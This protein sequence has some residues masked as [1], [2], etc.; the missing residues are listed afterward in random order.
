MST[1]LAVG[2]PSGFPPGTDPTLQLTL[3]P[4]GCNFL[5][6]LDLRLGEDKFVHSPYPLKMAFLPSEH[7]LLYAVKFGDLPWFDGVWQ[8]HVQTRLHPVALPEGTGMLALQIIVVNANTGKVAALRLANLDRACTALLR[9]NSEQQLATVFDPAGAD[10]WV[11][12]QFARYD[13]SS[14]LAKAALASCTLGKDDPAPFPGPALGTT[15]YHSPLPAELERWYTYLED[16]GHSI[17][18][19]LTAH[20]KP[21][22]NDEN[23]VP[24][25]VKAVTDKGWTVSEEG[26]ILV[27]LPYDNEYGLTTDPKYDEYRYS[28]R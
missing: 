20:Y 23:L 4:G 6:L 12:A 15:R 13:T 16:A 1:M 5:A 24:A 14:K 17:N 18:V 8:A 3:T 21:G 9:E 10:A 7:A 25:P 11:Q 2:Q 28:P 26:Y 27:D 22:N 19:V